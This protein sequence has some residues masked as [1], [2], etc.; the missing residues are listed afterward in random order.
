MAKINGRKAAETIAQR[1]D[2][3]SHGA[4]SART[5]APTDFAPNFYGSQ[6][7]REHRDALFAALKAGPVYVVFSYE[8]PI[9]WFSKHDITWHKPDVKYSMTTSHHQSRCPRDGQ[10]G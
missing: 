10:K 1:I 2:F 3:T 4:L 7:P 6:L 8:T 9:A 5:Y